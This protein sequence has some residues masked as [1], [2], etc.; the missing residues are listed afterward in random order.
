[1]KTYVKHRPGV[2]LVELMVVLAVISVLMAI[3]IPSI[4]MMREA[5]RRTSCGNNLHQFGVAIQHK[6]SVPL[7][8]H[9]LARSMEGSNEI[10]HC[11]S[12]GAGNEFAGKLISNYTVC[13][14]GTQ[15]VEFS[16]MDRR[17]FNGAA[18]HQFKEIL[19]G[20]SYTIAIGEVLF[21]AGSWDAPDELRDHWLKH[22]S[23]RGPS[24]VS[25]FVSST[26]VHVNAEK[27]EGVTAAEIELSFSS[28]HG[29]GAQ[30]VFADGHVKWITQTID[31][32]IWS[33][34]GTR[35]RGDVGILK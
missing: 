5:S 21:E 17:L 7:Q 10:F 20:M 1:M 30:V 28:F 6:A 34:L 29:R 14:S 22:E 25:E 23:A 2:T 19:D 3:M 26:G 32:D 15:K 4:Q 31:P 8:A 11:P 13:G 33:A 9:C 16:R 18:G 12:S 35:S 27:F 24:E